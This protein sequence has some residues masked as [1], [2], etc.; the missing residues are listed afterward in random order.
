MNS[1]MN[2][3]RVVARNMPATAN[4]WMRAPKEN[5]QALKVGSFVAS[6]CLA[7]IA[8][9]VIP[10]RWTTSTE[11]WL[12]AFVILT[13]VAILLEFVSVPLPNS[14]SITVA[15]IAHI[16]TILLVPAPFAAISVGASVFVEE[17]VRR[18][19]V[20]RLAF[21]VGGMLVTSSLCSL[22]LGFT[23]DIWTIRSSGGPQAFLL[24]AF[25][26]VG[27]TYHAV[28]LVLTS[29][30]FAITSGRSITHVLRANTRGT[31]LNDAG[32]ASV[33]AFAALIWTVE[34]LLATLLV[35]P[36]A[37]VSRSF[38][39]SHRL[40]VET[41]SAVRSLADIVDDRDATTYHHSERVA[42]YS[43]AL[44]KE[45]GLTEDQLEV[46]EQAA[47]V[48]DLGKIGVPDR[49]L[50]KPGPLTSAEFAI[51]RLHTEIGPRILNQFDLFHEGAAIV[52]HHHESYDGSGYPEGLA[53][54]AIPYGARVVAVADAF[55]AMTS[56]RPYR[57]ALSASEAVERLR[58]GRGGQWDPVVVDAFLLLFTAGAIERSMKIHDPVLVAVDRGAPAHQLRPSK[59]PSDGGTP[60]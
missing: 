60:A 49:V 43:L 3:G 12:P 58:A 13:A 16:A 52:R 55:D 14:G 42:A 48:H 19:P 38:K 7:G 41:R 31:L 9:L 24:P 37:V 2:L 21:N 56:D 28:N 51:M 8:S 26:V 23:G 40:E 15:T 18:A 45:L 22:A 6:V 35:L 50:L 10:A 4:R 17:A 32:A 34:P 39:H 27:L 29:I 20:P 11:H 47:A 33:G 53:G 59:A 44:G 46:I 54:D 36:A 1:S 25:L 30:V 57:S 5:K